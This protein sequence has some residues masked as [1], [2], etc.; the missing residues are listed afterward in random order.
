MNLG[1]RYSVMPCACALGMVLARCVACACPS[2][3]QSVPCACPVAC[4]QKV[5]YPSST[6]R[7][8]FICIPAV[9]CPPPPLLSGLVGRRMSVFCW[10][11]SNTGTSPS[12]KAR[13]L[14]V[15]PRPSGREPRSFS[16]H[17]SG[18]RSAILRLG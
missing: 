6:L 18:C 17:A 11:P 3:T 8:A 16:L 12:L 7:P 14:F 9:V 10:S 1:P 4:V 15:P 2:H 5:P 13:F